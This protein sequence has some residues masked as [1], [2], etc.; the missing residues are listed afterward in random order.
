MPETLGTPTGRSPK[1]WQGGSPLGGVTPEPQVASPSSSGRDVLL[2]AILLIAALAAGACTL[3]SWRDIGTQVPYRETGWER[4][5]GSLGHGWV[6][7]V[8]GVLLA[9][10]AVLV[11]AG[12]ERAGRLLAATTGTSLMLF[13]VLEWGLG[14]K[15]IRSGPGPGLWVLF[16]VGLVVVVAVGMLAPDPEP[17]T[18]S[19]YG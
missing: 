18:A 7:V 11:A 12:K 4:I 19:V 16:L 1:T 2:T 3:M 17:D 5:D 10:A 13:T 9:V 8:L 6:A 14:M 15:G